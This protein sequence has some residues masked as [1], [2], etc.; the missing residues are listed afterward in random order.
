LKNKE[1]SL[2]ILTEEKEELSKK[3]AQLEKSLEEKN[4]VAINLK[5]N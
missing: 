5:E 4:F 2:I 3:A 1:I